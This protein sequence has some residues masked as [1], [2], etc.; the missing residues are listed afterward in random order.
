MSSHIDK[1]GNVYEVYCDMLDVTSNHRPNTGWMFIDRERH[2]HCWVETATGLRAAAYDPSK[3]Y[4]VPTVEF[5]RTGSWVDDD[6]EEH[7]SGHFE[8]KFCRDRVELAFMADTEQR[9]IPGTKHCRINGE[10][11][12]VEEFRRRWEARRQE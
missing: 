12:T 4:E 10:S 5:V 7:E 1:D 11:V 3:Q 8:C 6:G 2:E 9:F